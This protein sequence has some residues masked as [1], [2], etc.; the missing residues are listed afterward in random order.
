MMLPTS[1]R[2]RKNLAEVPREESLAGLIFALPSLTTPQSP[3]AAKTVERRHH[4]LPPPQT[5]STIN[6]LRITLTYFT[7]L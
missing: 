4:A 5:I 3:G 1:A 6:L 7:Y 2:K